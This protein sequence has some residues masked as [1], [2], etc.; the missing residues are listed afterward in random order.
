[1]PLLSEYG[2]HI[3]LTQIDENQNEK[4]LFPVNTVEDVYVDENGN[5]LVDFLPKIVDNLSNPT[6]ESPLTA[7]ESATGELTDV[8]MAA[9]L[10]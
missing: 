9:L 2:H 7:T 3:E 8:V 4:T 10:S 5:S 6:E 1:M